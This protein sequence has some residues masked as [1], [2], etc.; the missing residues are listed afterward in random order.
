[1]SQEANPEVVE[2]VD[3]E[4]ITIGEV[5]DVTG[6]SQSGEGDENIVWGT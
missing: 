4:P 5:T 6:A 1:M 2:V 3:L